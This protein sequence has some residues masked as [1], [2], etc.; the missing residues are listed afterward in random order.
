PALRDEAKPADE[1]YAAAMAAE[2]PRP[3][4]QTVLESP[5]LEVVVD[6]VRARFSTWYE[7][8]PRSARADGRHATFK[9][10]VALLPYV[11][12]MGFDVLYFPPIHPIGTTA[13]KGR[14][15]AVSAQ[16]GDVGSPWAIGA[17]E[18]G[19]KAILPELGTFADFDFLVQEAG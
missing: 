13:R 12:E 19:H 1:R 10:C 5:P 7:M 3:A 9:D 15:N 2:P 6:P 16:P 8:F 18:G 4:P 17:A 11:Q 14:N